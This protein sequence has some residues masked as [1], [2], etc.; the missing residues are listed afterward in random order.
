MFCFCLAHTLKGVSAN[1]IYC[2]EAAYMDK[3]VFFEVLVPLMEI[4]GTATICISTPL[5]SGNFYSELT[6][7]VDDKGR[8][9]FNVKHIGK[10]MRPPWKPLHTYNKVRLYRRH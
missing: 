4:A 9:I 8:P 10:E 2:E 5:G 6:R 7:L 1:V 3:I